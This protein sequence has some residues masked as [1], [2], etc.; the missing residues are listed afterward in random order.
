MQYLEAMGLSD[1]TLELAFPHFRK[2]EARGRQ[3]AFGD[4]IA[5][6]TLNVCLKEAYIRGIDLLRKMSMVDLRVKLGHWPKDIRCVVRRAVLNLHTRSA[7][8]AA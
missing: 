8:H 2:D 6:E 4:Q 1:N 3:R 5:L 7:K